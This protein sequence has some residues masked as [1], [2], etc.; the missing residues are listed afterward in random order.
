MKSTSSVHEC[1]CL[2]SLTINIMMPTAPRMY[3]ANTI[4]ALARCVPVDR[5][6]TPTTVAPKPIVVNVSCIWPFF[7]SDHGE[8]SGSFVSSSSQAFR[9]PVALAAGTFFDC[10]CSPWGTRCERGEVQGMGLL[11]AVLSF[12][13][14]ASSLMTPSN[15][16]NSFISLLHPLEP[17]LHGTQPLQLSRSAVIETNMVAPELMS[18]TVRPSLSQCASR[19]MRIRVTTMRSIAIVRF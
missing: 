16:K 19:P 13:R 12:S 2:H 1:H 15:L 17:A 4:R 9:V 10:S 7:R 6:N 3:P 11:Q 18:T 8:S 14:A 5:H